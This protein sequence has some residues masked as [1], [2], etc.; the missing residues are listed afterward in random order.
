MIVVK[1]QGGLGN[2]MFQYAAAKR[3]AVQHNTDVVLDLRWFDEIPETDTKRWYELDCFKI[4]KNEFRAV[5]YQVI[6]MGLGRKTKLKLNIK[7]FGRKKKLL[8][9]EAPDNSFN[10]KALSLPNNVYLDGWFTSEKYF[11][12]IRSELVKDFSFK[13]KPSVKSE[14]ILKRITGSESVS[15]HVRRGDYI[16]NKHASKW[17]GL[18][19]LAYYNSA[20]KIVTRKIKNPEL[21]VFSDD[22]DWCK[23]NLKF[24]FPTTYV[25]HNNKG[26]E[27]LRLMMACNN[28]IITNSTFSWW[29]AWLNHNPDKVVVAPKKWL[30]DPSVDTKDVIPE[31]WLKI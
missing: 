17:H 2:Q 15:V 8:G 13:G 5:G 24:K 27:D 22:P 23:A 25:S 6:S 28:N 19:G 31:S 29:G 11:A 1:L 12:D 4:E 10:Q 20:V 14:Q 21:F 16:F 18:T 9:F 7:A 26:S 3:L 30:S